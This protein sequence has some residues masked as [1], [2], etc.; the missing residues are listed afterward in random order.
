[1][2]RLR[3][4]GLRAVVAVRT[5]H[6]TNGDMHEILFSSFEYF[7]GPR[8]SSCTPIRNNM[9]CKSGSSPN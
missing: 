4:P 6:P 2:G 8:P 5:E 1:M 7:I 9:L 3:G